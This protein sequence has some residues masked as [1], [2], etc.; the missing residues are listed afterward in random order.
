VSV[1]TAAVRTLGV[2]AGAAHVEAC[3]TPNGPKL[4]ELGARCGGGGTPDSI[5][6][7]VTGVDMLSEVVR[8]HAGD[9][10]HNLVPAAARGCCYRFLTPGPGTLRSV[11]GV[12]T[13]ATWPGVLDCAVTVAGG[14]EIR[15]VRV[16]SDRAGFVITGAETRAGAERL[17][18]A[19]EQEIR[20]VYA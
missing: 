4:F 5:V 10:P 15:P 19:A 20:F 16:G 11:N 17:A 1:V 2:T 6:P 12:E 8:L 3:S 7:F 14:Q 13:V 18:D 9:P